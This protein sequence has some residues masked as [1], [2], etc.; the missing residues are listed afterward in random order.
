MLLSLQY[1]KARLP[2]T[3]KEIRC[4][5]CGFHINFEVAQ[6]ARGC[7]LDVES[8]VGPSVKVLRE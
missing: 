3:L 2:G 4:G 6:V 5:P 8:F 7:A 1:R